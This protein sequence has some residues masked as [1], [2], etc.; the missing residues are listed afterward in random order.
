MEGP[1]VQRFRVIRA[2]FHNGMDE[3]SSCVLFKAYVEHNAAISIRA[4]PFSSFLYS[5]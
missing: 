4:F 5:L 3:C 2:L 1:I